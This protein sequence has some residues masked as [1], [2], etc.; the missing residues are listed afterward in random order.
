MMFQYLM[1]WLGRRND[2]SDAQKGWFMSS[3]TR[4]VLRQ[5]SQHVAHEIDLISP[6]TYS[7][8][9]I[10]GAE[11]ERVDRTI[12]RLAITLA[13]C[14]EYDDHG[15]SAMFL[16]AVYLRFNRQLK[17]L[18]I[19]KKERRAVVDALQSKVGVYALIGLST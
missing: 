16:P 8:L 18:G 15:K 12:N 4:S 6:D 19:A 3:D 5:G 9:A 2:E 1:Q 11:Q 17:R 13:E 7:E 14:K 10:F